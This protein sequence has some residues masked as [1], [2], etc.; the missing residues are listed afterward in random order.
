VRLLGGLLGERQRTVLDRSID[1]Q[2]AQC[3]DTGRI[4]ALRLAWKPGSE[5]PKPHIFWDSDLA[6]WI[7][8]AAYALTIEPDPALEAQ[9]DG[10]VGLLAG[11]QQPDGYLN[12]HFSA[13]EPEKRFTNLR[14][15]HELY[16]AGH[17][18]EAAVAYHE[19]TGKRAMLDVVCR[20]VDCI[21]RTFGRSR[22]RAWVR[23]PR[24]DRSSPS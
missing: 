5:L 9:V 1:Q 8:S 18:V 2:Y 6:K 13:V 21:D 16:C 12:S 20:Y 14:D 22:A 24:G 19:A 23:R 15:L 7:E 4:D 10:V 17:L 11:A 3:R